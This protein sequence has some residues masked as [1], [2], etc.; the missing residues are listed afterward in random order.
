LPRPRSSIDPCLIDEGRHER[1]SPSRRAQH[2]HYQHEYSWRKRI[3]R[4][5]GCIKESI[6]ASE[7]RLQDGDGQSTSGDEHLSGE[8]GKDSSTSEGKRLGGGSDSA[9]GSTGGGTTSRSLD[10]TVGDLGDGL[11]SAG[12]GLNLTV[13]DLGDGLAGGGSLD[14]TVRDLS[15]GSS[16]RSGSL[17]LAVRDLGDSDTSSGC[18]DLTVGDL[19]DGG[20]GRGLDLTIGDLGDSLGGGGSLELTVANLSGS[21]AG[22]NTTSLE[23]VDVDGGALVTSGLV[24]EVVEVTAQAL[25]EDGRGA[26]GKSAVAADGETRGVDGTGLGRLVELELVVG[27]NVTSTA[28]VVSQDTVVKSDSQDL[29]LTSIE[30]AL[31]GGGDVSN[32]DAE[33]TIEA[34]LAALRSRLLGGNGLGDTLGEGGGDTGEGSSDSEGLHVDGNGVFD[35]DRV[36]VVVG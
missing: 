24:V 25:V 16:G 6:H 28:L 34:G 11:S 31:G 4:E 8:G 22:S 7:R 3:G 21:T 14:L 13:G 33:G 18:L 27:S 30:T 2:A 12:R 23:D 32:G 20:T 15:D 5:S 29:G 19:S 10:L 35:D 1:T 26:D 9:V 36:V 17:N